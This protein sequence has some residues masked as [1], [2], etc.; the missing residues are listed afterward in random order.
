MGIGREF[1]NIPGYHLLWRS[2]KN[3][4]IL[5]T[6]AALHIYPVAATPASLTTPPTYLAACL[7]VLNLGARCVGLPVRGRLAPIP[8]GL[9]LYSLL[10][11]RAIG[12]FIGLLLTM[13]D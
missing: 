4:N 9:V 2:K 10:R 6:R 11:H 3:L 8:G 7:L 1:S 12:C 13:C 5:A